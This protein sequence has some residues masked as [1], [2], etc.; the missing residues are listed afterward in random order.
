MTRVKEK[1]FH[2]LAV[3]EA[4]STITAEEL[5]ELDAL[6]DLRNQENRPTPAE[7]KAIKKRNDKIK[8]LIKE[9]EKRGLW[10]CS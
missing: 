2:R 10:S 1:R 5:V 7:L 6:T 3:K 4:L 9:L 8:K